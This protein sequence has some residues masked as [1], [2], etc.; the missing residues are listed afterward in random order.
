[1]SFVVADKSATAA[2]FAPAVPLQPVSLSV[3]LRTP[4]T[5]RTTSLRRP[6]CAT[7]QPNHVAPPKNPVVHAARTLFDLFPQRA[8]PQGPARDEDASRLPLI[9]PQNPDKQQQNQEKQNT[10]PSPSQRQHQQ[11]QNLFQPSQPETSVLPPRAPS[12]FV[13]EAVRKVGPAVVRIDTETTVS[14]LTGIPPGL[15]SL[16]DDPGFKKY[17][18]DEFGGRLNP[19]KTRLE[20]GLGSGFIIS[21]DGLIVTNAHVVK[22][23][24]KLT[25]TLTDGRTFVGRVS[26]TDDL[27]DLA[28]VKIDP[29]APTS[30]ATIFAGNEDR[31]DPHA[32]TK[33]DQ[34]PTRRLPLFGRSNDSHNNVQSEVTKNEL[35]VAQL[36]SSTDVNVGDWCIAVGNP[37]GLNNTV[38][39]GIV[40]SLNRSAAEVGIPEK[41]LNLIQTSAPLN[42]GN[43]GGVIANEFGEVIGVATAVRANAEGIGFA[44]PIDRVKDI[45]AELANGK[46]IAHPFVGIK[47]VT[48]T[49]D[50]ARQNNSN[51]NAPAI[52]PEVDGAIVLHVIPESPAAQPLG[53]RRFDIIVGIDGKKCRGVKDVQTIVERAGVGQRLN[54]QV[55][56]GGDKTKP[57]DV[58]IVTGDLAKATAQDA[59]VIIP[60]PSPF[61]DPRT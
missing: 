45:V 20:H 42:A 49:P 21:T 30:S 24:D 40:S 29:T 1:M 28:V 55:I 12:S 4:Q 10:F 51:P 52:I 38:T 61:H 46:T 26:G 39:L 11:Q 19:P 32:A 53:L 54:V 5:D 14:G 18:A 17:F 41:R 6:P 37:H 33:P 16:F 34:D 59:P 2:A 50:F 47:M 58:S 8:P 25:V 3:R 31:I 35:P 56:R 36:G 60:V 48:L 43:S 57:I 22:G 7:I 44:I 13:A 27:L 23:A 15:E 9:V